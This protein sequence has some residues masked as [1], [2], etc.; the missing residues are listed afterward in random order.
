MAAVGCY[1]VLQNARVK[2]LILF[3]L[4]LIVLSL[5]FSS[6]V[7]LIDCLAGNQR[8]HRVARMT[9]N[10]NGSNEKSLDSLI[11]KA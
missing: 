6:P 10:V 5:S 4:C 11:I 1:A 7:E 2:Q 9:F 8:R 3:V